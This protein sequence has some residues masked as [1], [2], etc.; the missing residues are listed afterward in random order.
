M[1]YIAD[2][3]HRAITDNHLESY[4]LPPSYV[5]DLRTS[6]VKQYCTENTALMWE[7]FKD[8]VNYQNSNAWSL[9]CDYVKDNE[10]IMFFNESDD[11]NAFLIPNGAELQKILEDSFGF[12]F[13]ITNKNYSYL[14]CFNHHDILY[15]SGE[16]KE[17]VQRLKF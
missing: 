14:I 15:G 9:I 6:I 4:L 8:C 16:A 2:E 3:I 12:E 5:E 7:G 10:C 13:Y 1:G 17:W 11:K